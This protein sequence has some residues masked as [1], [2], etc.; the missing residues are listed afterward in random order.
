MIKNNA[1]HLS[2]ICFIGIAILGFFMFQNAIASKKT[3]FDIIKINKDISKCNEDISGLT[4]S[5]S[6]LHKMINNIQKTDGSLSCPVSCQ[7]NNVATNDAIDAI[8]LVDINNLKKIIDDKEI[9]EY[10]DE[11]DEIDADESV[12]SG[13]TTKNVDN[14]N[15]E[16]A[17]DLCKQLGLSSK[18][19]RDVLVARIK[20][21][22]YT[23]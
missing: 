10:G 5:L 16:Q 14:F 22:G 20:Q 3:T 21:S 4:V 8:E 15:Y 6:H 23:P 7:T 17:R 9:E 12:D 11:I 2:L 13:S 19:K 18:G 1:M